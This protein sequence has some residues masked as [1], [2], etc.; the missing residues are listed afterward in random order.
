M[1]EGDDLLEK[2]NTVWD[3][4]SVNI[5]KN[6]IANLS[7]TKIFEN[8][9]YG[10]EV[11]DEVTDFYDKETP[12]VDSNHTCVAVISLDPALNKEANFYPQVFLKECTHYFHISNLVAKA[13]GLNL[14][15][16]L[17]SLL[18]NREALD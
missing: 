12:K 17:S 2:Y 16:K 8:W 3:K 4:V 5:K 11:G 15:K 6:L 10:D 13:P 18:S 7:L 1:I 14:S 9:N